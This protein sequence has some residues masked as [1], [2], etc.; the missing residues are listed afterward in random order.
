M[1]LD[2][3]GYSCPEPVITIMKALHDITAGFHVIVDN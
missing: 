2:T 1:R 3:S